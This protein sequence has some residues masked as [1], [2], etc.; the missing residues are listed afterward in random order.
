[1][2]LKEGWGRSIDE[3]DEE[4]G[5]RGGRETRGAPAAGARGEFFPQQNKRGTGPHELYRKK[6]QRTNKTTT[7]TVI[8]Q[9]TPDKKNK[10]M[11]LLLLLLLLVARAF[12]AAPMPAM[13]TAT[14]TATATAATTAATNTL[15]APQE[16]QQWTEGRATWYQDNKRGACL[17]VSLFFCFCWAGGGAR[18]NRPTNTDA[19]FLVRRRPKPTTQPHSTPPRTL[20]T[21]RP[22]HN[23]NKN[24]QQQQLLRLRPA[25]LRCL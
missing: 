18:P 17:W 3:E 24:T 16:P 25:L 7:T 11:R 6:K 22:T 1:L 4:E 5:G 15:Q 10:K 8:H 21:Q 14:A 19:A 20:I 9:P 23:H 13:A 12:D 2:G